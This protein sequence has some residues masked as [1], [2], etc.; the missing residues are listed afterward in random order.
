MNN[1]KSSEELKGI[2]RQQLMGNYGTAAGMLIVV[3]LISTTAA[4]LINYLVG[5]YTRYESTTSF[6]IQYVLYILI[7]IIFSLLLSVFSMGMNYF[8]LKVAR[9]QSHQFEDLFWGFKNHPDKMI[10]LTFII[11]MIQ[12]ICILP[13]YLLIFFSLLSGSWVLALLGFV[14]L[15][16]GVITSIILMLRYNLSALVLADDS[17]KGVK[18]VM[19][20]STKLMKGNKGRCFYLIISFFG[21][22]LLMLLSFGIG[23]FWIAPYIS[24]TFANFYL[25]IREEETYRNLSADQHSNFSQNI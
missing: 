18:Q 4:I 8:Y 21:W 20:E 6:V 22:F 9:Q 12:V 24:T 14:I 15:L 23:Y 11:T 1:Q 3:F 25:D 2:A 5:D 7:N 19:Q 13:G 10:I 16:I 17:S